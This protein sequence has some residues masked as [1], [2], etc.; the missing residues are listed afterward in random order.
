MDNSERHR[1][2]CL[3]RYYESMDIIKANALKAEYS[4]R[5]GVVTAKSRI[6]VKRVNRA[7][8]YEF[9]RLGNGQCKML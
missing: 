7:K 2:E 6:F 3:R 1:L 8:G 9:V 5:N 4:G